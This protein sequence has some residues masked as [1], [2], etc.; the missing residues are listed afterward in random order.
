MSTEKVLNK[1]K[2]VPTTLKET[3]KTLYIY[4]D[5]KLSLN[6]IFTNIVIAS[7]QPFILAVL[8]LRLLRILTISTSWIIQLFRLCVF[9]LLLIPAW[10]YLLITYFS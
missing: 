7:K 1:E 6:I 4:W 8:T 9:S 2:H 3:I 10:I 5:Y